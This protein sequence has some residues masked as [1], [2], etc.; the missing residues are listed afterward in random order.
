M[1]ACKMKR[2]EK[3]VFYRFAVIGLIII[4]IACAKIGSPTGGPKDVTPPKVVVTK[5]ADS[6]INFV[7]KKDHYFFR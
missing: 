6:T 3:I 4:C 5:P 2:V 7:P 1:S